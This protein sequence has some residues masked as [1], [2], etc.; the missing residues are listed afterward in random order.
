[1]AVVAGVALAALQYAGQHLRPASV[2]IA[3]G[4]VVALRP[5]TRRLLPPGTLRLRVGLPAMIGLRGLVAGAFFGAEA[6]IPLTLTRVHGYGAA[7]A[8]TP[9]AASALGWWVG[10][11]WLDRHPDLS[12]SRQIRVGCTLI[13]LGSTGLAAIAWP[14][15]PGW[16]AAPVWGIASAGMGLSVASLSMLVIGGSAEQ[17]R[18]AN[19][20]S[21][22]L[23]DALASAACI[24]LAGILLA[25]VPNISVA[26]MAIDAGMAAVAAWAALM[27]HR[28]RD[29]HLAAEPTEDE[30]P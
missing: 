3:V 28:V 6:F 22:Q 20:A 24:G 13:A 1:M 18:G 8:G 10:S 9:L 17:R 25:L 4:G 27:A 15:V 5:A 12:W 26:I 29:D 14:G 11:R 7:A 2:P 19:G 23:C 16:P 30:S 21:L